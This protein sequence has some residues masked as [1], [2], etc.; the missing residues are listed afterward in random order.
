MAQLV[1]TGRRRG[2]STTMCSFEVSINGAP[3]GSPDIVVLD[4]SIFTVP[5]QS[6]QV[7]IQASSFDPSTHPSFGASFE[8]DAFGDVLPVF[9]PPECEPPIL[10]VTP[11]TRTIFVTMHF[12]PYRDVTERARQSLNRSG[13]DFPGSPPA[14]PPG[15]MSFRT[16]AVP[17]PPA[18]M[19]PLPEEVDTTFIAAPS[20][21]ATKI[22]IEARTLTPQGEVMILSLTGVSAPSV[23]AVYWPDAVPRGPGAGPAPFL[24]YFHPT[25]AQNVANGFFTDPRDRHDPVT[26]STYPWGFDFQFF[27][28]WRYLTYQGDSFTVDPFC[29]GLPYQIEASG[30]NVVLVLPLNR[31]GA[32]PCDE[33]QAFT[34]AA[35]LQEYLEELQ[36]FM[37]RRA[38]NFLSP[39]IGRLGM[40]SFSSGHALLSCFLAKAA[41]QSHPLYLDALQ[42]VYLFDPHA[43]QAAETLGPTTN[44]ALWASRGTAAT[45]V[46]RLYTQ[47]DPA[48][49]APLLAQLGLSGGVAP[50]DVTTPDGRKSVACL[51]L[52]SW[53][54]LATS[55]GSGVP[56]AN[57]GQV[58]QG[59]SA[60]MLTDALRR[61]AF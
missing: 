14:P 4:Q 18:A 2:Q 9:L 50:F 58:H 5:D 39:G 24:V 16:A 41:N 20:L 38:G 60:L 55:V 54:S 26:G 43:D 7:A 45:K 15:D 13:P 52:A 12:T 51:P 32:T 8:I 61:S 21:A 10:V 40:A 33:V 56:Y 23:V 44:V 46:A 1:I 31:V 37:F 47:N 35:F 6:A 30:R 29:K 17:L 22:Q 28:I 11:F 57:T 53:N 59:M 36:G 19:S 34:D 48:T 49:V 27:G 42:E 3:F 25:M